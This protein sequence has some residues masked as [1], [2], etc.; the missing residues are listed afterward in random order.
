MRAAAV[1]SLAAIGARCPS[2]RDRIVIILRRSLADSDDEV[3]RR[4]PP[5]I[6]S[7]KKML[8]SARYCRHKLPRTPRL[9]KNFEPQTAFTA[10]SFL[11]GC[12]VSVGYLCEQLAAWI[13]LA[14]AMRVI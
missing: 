6:R 11:S 14:M 3:R 8:P 1:S 10:A 2:L 13:S 4:L 7:V 12:T 5:Q 9:N